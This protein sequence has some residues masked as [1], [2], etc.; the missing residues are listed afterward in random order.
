MT[1]RLQTNSVQT[2]D[3]QQVDQRL[4]NCLDFI[5]E[6]VSGDERPYLSVEVFGESILGL[7]DSGASRTVLGAKGG[8]IFRKFRLPLLPSESTSCT[9]ANGSP[10]QVVGSYDIPFRVKDKVKIINT[11]VVPSLPHGLILGFDFWKKMGIIP[12][13]RHGEWTFADCIEFPLPEDPSLSVTEAEELNKLLEGVFADMPANLGCTGLVEHVIRTKA[14]PIKQRYHPLSPAMRKYVDEA[15]DAMLAEGIVE[16]SNS[17]WSSPIVLVRKKDSSYRFCVDF[18]AVNKVTERDAYPLPFITHT[19]DKLR[20]AKY[21]SSLDIKSAYWQ[22]PLSVESRSITA[23]TVPNRGL[24]QFRRMPMGLHNSSATWQRLIDRV[25]GAD[26]EPYVFVYLDDIVIVTQEFGK[27]LEVLREVF[28]RLKKAGLTVAR[29]KCNFCR[30]ELKF[31]GYIVDR[32]G[33]HVDPE[34]VSAIVNLPVP[35]TVR[36][37][38]QIVGMASWYRRFIPNFA[39]VMAPITVL[40]RKA[41]PFRWTPECDDA[42]AK[43]KELLITAPVMNCPDFDLPFCVQTDASDFG[44]GAVLTQNHPDGERVISYISRSLTSSERK[45][46]TTEKEALAVLWAIE[47]F[48][49]Y[50]EGTRFTVVTDHFALKWLNDLKDPCGRLARWSVRLQQYDFDVIHR[51]GKENVVPDALSRSVPV[52]ELLGAQT[53]PLADVVDPWYCKIFRQVREHP[54]RFPNWRV[55]DKQL[56][57]RVRLEYPELEGTSAWK[58][59]VPK[60][61]RRKIISENHDIPQAGHAGVYKTFHRIAQTY[62]WP[63]MR[64]DI[65]KYVRACTICATCK[66]E[67]RAPSGQMLGFPRATQP[68]EIISVD[69]VGPLPRSKSGHTCILSVSDYFS[70]FCMF[71]PMRSATAKTIV[72]LLEDSVFLLFG[73]PRQLICDNGKQFTSREMR[74]LMDTYGVKLLHTANYHPQA[75]PCERQHRTLKTMLS[76][77]IG[78]NQRD[79]DR[80]LQKVACAIRT[81]KHEST[82]HTPYFLNFGKEMWIRGDRQEAEKAPVWPD[83]LPEKRPWPLILDKVYRDVRTRLVRAWE[84]SRDR[85]NLRHRDIRLT[86]GQRVW[87]KNHVLSNALNYYTAK[88]AP[89]FRGP[90]IVRRVVSPWTYELQDLQGVSRGIWHIKDLKVDATDAGA[91]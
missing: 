84:R 36:Q 11:L 12:N 55:E 7:L 58:R 47:R 22:V 15:L 9:V 17:P 85:Y 60:E 14:E 32:N 74:N 62:Y 66:V 35:K 67:P 20:D 72:T 65:A 73:A 90:F 59:V 13:V 68:W 52:L 76:S 29:E 48:R 61:I 25:L 28:N 41:H 26:L 37:V 69:V 56:W 42:F 39:S 19:L 89:K 57:R 1:A 8:E 88:L 24:Y 18:R 34:K 51:K 4:V 63:K 79:W 54:L 53:D 91:F 33:L 50:I 23:F 10:C 40:L 38:R 49:P 6:S 46:S 71:F 16:P 87:R 45:F 44:L 5:L 83:D 75:N 3:V 2:H 86:K 77:F 81:A 43:L 27:H 31:L 30:P 70:K 80:L 21:L 82:G 78:D 64:A